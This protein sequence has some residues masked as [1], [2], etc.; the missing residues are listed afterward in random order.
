MRGQNYG[1]F[2][3]GFKEVVPVIESLKENYNEVLFQSPHASPYIFYAF[4][5]KVDPNYI[6]LLHAD[7]TKAQLNHIYNVKFSDVDWAR[8][9][10]KI[11]TLLVALS[12]SLPDYEFE[13]RRERVKAEMYDP[14][15][16]LNFRVVE[17][18][19]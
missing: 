13:H 15:G 16:Y 9:R 6:Q 5:A 3:Y 2:Q 12:P 19:R 4:Y 18:L 10:E 14:A 7:Q 1:H 11:K 17:T 8:D